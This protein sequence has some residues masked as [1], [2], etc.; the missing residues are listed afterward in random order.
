MLLRMHIYNLFWSFYLVPIV[1]KAVFMK[2]V[3]KWERPYL[4]WLME[5]QGNI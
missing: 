4:L 2:N 1:L 5:T 3:L